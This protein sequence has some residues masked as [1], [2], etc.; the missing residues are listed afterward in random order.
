MPRVDQLRPITL[1][2]L[3]NKI[4]SKV[5]TNR[6]LKVMRK[7]KFPQKFIDWV[8]MCH[9]GAT[10]CFIL[11]FLTNPIDLLIS[12]RQG[13]CLAMCLFILYM[14]PLLCMI[15]R[16]VKGVFFKGERFHRTW[17]QGHWKEWDNAERCVFTKDTDYVDDVNICI[18]DEIDLI[19]VDEI[20]LKFEDMSGAILNRD[21]K[22]KIMGIGDWR[23][24]DRWVLPWIK[25]VPSLKIFG[26][27]FHPTY[28]EILEDNWEKTVLE[29]DKCLLAWKTRSLESIFQKVELLKTFAIPKLCYKALLLPLPG[30]VA[31]KLEEKMRSFIWRGKLEKPATAEMF[32]PVE[33]GGLGL[34]C[35]RT[36]AD[37]LLLKQ[38]L[39]MMEDKEATH[40]DHLKFWLGKFLNPVSFPDFFNYP[41]ALRT[42]GQ[43]I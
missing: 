12:V 2:N 33:E 42:G 6:L 43:G 26:I 36:K 34:T 14:E 3:D 40:H 32:N 39:R 41:R 7:M 24:K 4:L 17:L 30:K 8:K 20:F 11:N 10:T 25:T 28:Q 31:Q 16:S 19:K 35:L 38:V 9:D 15:R 27:I 37:S 1:L 18:Q 29:F 23:G 21:F 22:T 13:D 5:V